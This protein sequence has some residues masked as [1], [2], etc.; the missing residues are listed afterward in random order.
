MCAD[1]CG[2]MKNE[3][4]SGNKYFLLFIDDFT[5]MCS[6]YFIRTKS[7]ALEHFKKFKALV[8][9]QGNTTI[10]TLWTDRGG[11]FMSQEFI[12]LCE[13]EWIRREMTTPH[14]PE[15]NGIAERKNRTI[16]EMDRSMLNTSKLLDVY[17]A[18]SVATAVYL[19][20]ISP[21]KTV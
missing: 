12:T 8:E 17:W 13:K 10:K 6:V 14:T 18:E 4:H 7:D 9:K 20:N 5:R 19:I 11:E 21:T 1:I 3:S 16:E 2:P 15:Q